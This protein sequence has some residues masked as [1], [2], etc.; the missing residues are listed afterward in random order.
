M[1]LCVWC[2]CLGCGA[3][4]CRS[5]MVPE[6]KAR[7]LFES[8]Q[9]SPPSSQA[10]FQKSTANLTDS[11]VSFELMATVFPSRSTSLPPHDQR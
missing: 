7:L 1:R 4:R 9:A 2:T 8:S 6:R 5:Q 10:S 11:R 3:P